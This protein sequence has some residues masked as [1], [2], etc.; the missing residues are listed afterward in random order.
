MKSDAQVLQFSDIKAY[1]ENGVLTVMYPKFQAGESA[2]A[3]RSIA[4]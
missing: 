1:L 3:P 4:R 2:R